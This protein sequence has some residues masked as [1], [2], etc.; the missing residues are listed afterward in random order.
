MKLSELP[1]RVFTEKVDRWTDLILAVVL[2]CLFVL[3]LLV[4]VSVSVE[5]FVSCLV[6]STAKSEI[7]KFLGIGMGGI[8]LA[9]QAKASYRRAK[10]MERAAHEQAKATNATEQGQRQ[11][12]LKNAIEH[13][14]HTSSDYVRLGGVYELF[15]LAE[16]TEELRKT[17][18]DMFC[19]HIRRTTGE[20]KYQE[21]YKEKPSE[22]V[23]SLLTLLFVQDHKVFKDLQANLQGSFLNGADLTRAHLQGANLRRA[24][25]QGADLRRAHLQGAYLGG[26][27]LQRAYLGGAYLQGAYLWVTHLQGAYLGGARLQGAYLG[28]THLQGA[29]L[30]ETHVQEAQL[31]GADLRGAGNLWR[32]EQ[33]FADRMH[34]AIGKESDLSGVVFEGGL[35]RE[36]VD[37]L[38]KDLSDTKANKLWI[39]L[40]RHVDRPKVIG[41]PEDCGARLDAYTKEDAEQWIAEYNKAM[42]EVPEKQ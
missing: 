6:G 8:L 21:E 7:L 12:R 41:L 36:D 4:M 10:A 25:L 19:V 28:G 18:L 5:K 2:V 22:E 23:Q 3:F 29:Y 26:A 38:V 17:A 11:E 16:E 39:A 13:F 9:L 35:S 32:S 42:S 24:H 27:R 15:H 40:E 1:E 31:F 20:A 34:A 33:S 37:S 30:G 14:G